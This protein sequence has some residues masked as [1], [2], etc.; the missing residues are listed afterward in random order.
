MATIVHENKLFKIEESEITIR[1]KKVK[2]HKIIE[3]DTVVI[4]PITRPGYTLLE[5]QYRPATGMIMRELPSGHVEKGEN[6][7]EAA[8]RELE[9]ETGFKADKVTFLTFFFSGLISKKESVYIAENLTIGKVHLDADESINAVKEVSISDCL[10]MI[11]NNQI[12]DPKTII[13]LLYYDHIMS[14]R[15]LPNLV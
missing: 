10:K 12:I 11:E 4:I 14:K 6:L 5:E 7:E 8:K 15:R 1:N 2:N 13:A 3:N 9:E